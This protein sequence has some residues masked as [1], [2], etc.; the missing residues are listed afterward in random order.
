MAFM[1]PNALADSLGKNPLAPGLDGDGNRLRSGPPAVGRR[2]A[3]EL[4]PCSVTLRHGH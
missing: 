2:V 1:L 4:R 3:G